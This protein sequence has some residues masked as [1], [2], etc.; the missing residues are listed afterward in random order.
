MTALVLK[1]LLTPPPL[2]LTRLLPDG[3]ITTLA[4]VS[5]ES[6]AAVT[7]PPG[8]GNSVF[9]HVQSTPASE[10]IINHNLGYRP[11]FTLYTVGGVQFFA[12]IDH[13]TLNQ[14]RVTLGTAL[15]GEAH[16]R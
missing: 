2:S 16:G 3:R 13:P 9:I 15:A 4:Q 7:A 11:D 10:W 1:R 14:T 6:I 5:P 12:G 8:A